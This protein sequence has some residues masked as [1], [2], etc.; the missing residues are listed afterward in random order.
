MNKLELL[1]EQILDRYDIKP[2]EVVIS[3]NKRGSERLVI[4]H[5]LICYYDYANNMFYGET[6]HWWLNKNA[7][8]NFYLPT[9]QV[10]WLFKRLDKLDNHLFRK[11]EVR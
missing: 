10:N 7:R 4:T 8:H 1:K 3:K 11:G 2:N 9:E 5:A 6:Q